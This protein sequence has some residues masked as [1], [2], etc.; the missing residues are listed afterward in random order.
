MYYYTWN[1]K[2]IRIY[3]SSLESKFIIWL[4][5]QEEAGSTPVSLMKV[6]IIEVGISTLIV[7]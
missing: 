1:P 4:Y 2:I 6:D 3:V 7:W 5:K